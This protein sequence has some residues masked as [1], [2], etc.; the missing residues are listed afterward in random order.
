MLGAKC[1]EAANFASSFAA[2]PASLSTPHLYISSLATWP[3]SHDYLGWHVFFPRIPS[4]ASVQS[5]PELDHELTHVGASKDFKRAI[6][7]SDDGGRVGSGPFDKSLPV[8][9]IT[10]TP[11]YVRERTGST[12]TGWLLDPSGKDRLMFVPPDAQL[13]DSL[14]TPAIG[15]PPTSSVDFTEAALGDQWTDCYQ[16]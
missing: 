13:R 10:T 11:R 15:A 7:G 12:Y 16:P 8:L 5:G 6:H 9:D 1:A 3:R 2:S 14:T 4:F